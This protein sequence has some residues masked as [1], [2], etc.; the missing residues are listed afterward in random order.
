MLDEA[1]K[2]A[3]DAEVEVDWIC[4]DA[5]QFAVTEPFD[6]CICALE[7]AFG[8]ITPEQD[9]TQHDL[10]I[11]QNVNAALKPGARF[12]LGVSNGFK[13]IRDYDQHSVKRGYFDAVHMLQEH[14]LTWTTSEGIEESATVRLRIYVPTEITTLLHQAQFEVEHIWGG[15][16]SRCNIVLD[17]Y[18]MT[19]VARKLG[20]LIR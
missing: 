11:L 9:S 16:D 15:T 7:A 14:E 18:I 1:R 17:G 20:A 6:G 5:A 4:C 8:F 13:S 10:A 2:A 3:A 12:I 19:F